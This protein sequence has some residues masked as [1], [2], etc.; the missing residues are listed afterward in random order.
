[1]HRYRRRSV[2]LCTVLALMI[3]ASGCRRPDEVESGPTKQPETESAEPPPAEPAT[4]DPATADPATA[5]DTAGGDE[6]PRQRICS[7]YVGDDA[8]MQGP[9]YRHHCSGVMRGNVKATIGIESEYVDQEMLDYIAGQG[10]DQQINFGP[11][12]GASF[13]DPAVIACCEHDYEYPNT[14]PIDD[15]E[16][17]HGWACAVDC[18]D[19]TCRA[20]PD[21]LRDF[22]EDPKYEVHLKNH[23]W[24]CA[25]DSD[26]PC[27]YDE[28]WALANYIAGHHQQC[29]GAF[30]GNESPPYAHQVYGRGGQLD[31]DAWIA[32]ND[33]GAGDAWPTITSVV[34]D[35]ECGIEPPDATGGSGWQLP[36]GPLQACTDSNDNNDEDPFGSGHGGGFGGIDTFA[37]ASGELELHG[38]MPVIA[39]IGRTSALETPESPGCEHEPCS[40]LSFH[41]RHGNLRLV[42]LRL[43]ASE[44]FGLLP[45]LPALAITD[46]RLQLDHPRTALLVP[47]PE[48]TSSFT[49]DSG[50]LEVIVSGTFYGVPTTFEA[51]NATPLHGTLADPGDGSSQVTLDPVTFAGKLGDGGQPWQLHASFG[52]WLAHAHAP[53]ARFEIN[54]ADGFAH[55]DASASSDADAEPLTFL[56]LVDGVETGSGSA[57]RLPWDPR[58]MHLVGL[59]VT[60]STGRTDWS[61]RFFM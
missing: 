18:I 36:P 24:P 10:L 50:T 35:G 29:V 22:A 3:I 52:S 6:T 60:D 19:Q 45:V 5:D 58:A 7:V 9:T 47:S 51:F 55:L 25:V 14:P 13:D 38:P 56:W 27:Y 17:E 34:I 61:S 46:L 20:V 43:S 59:R 26:L 53:R 48:G 21:L 37:V 41:A 23:P 31:L 1:M 28:I 39:D 4:A 32:D 54:W 57:L 33:P 49:F 40:R 15:P 44:A 16:A 30:L 11:T 42:D 8:L 12:Y 2:G